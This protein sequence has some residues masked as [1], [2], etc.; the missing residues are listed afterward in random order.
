VGAVGAGDVTG[1][2]GVCAVVITEVAVL[3]AREC[4]DDEQPARITAP[5]STSVS[6][7]FT[8]TPILQKQHTQHKATQD[9]LVRRSKTSVVIRI[10]R[11]DAE[12]LLRSQDAG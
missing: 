1:T 7:T 11:R 5:I 6:R 4:G 12:F 10:L 2:V 9:P 8:D 3:E